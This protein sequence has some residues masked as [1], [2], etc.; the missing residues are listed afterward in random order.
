M[1]SNWVVTQSRFDMA[2]RLQ[3]WRTKQMNAMAQHM[4]HGAGMLATA[5]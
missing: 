1:G 4:L 5:Q 2:L 3:S